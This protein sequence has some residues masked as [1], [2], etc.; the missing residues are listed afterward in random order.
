MSIFEIGLLPIGG[1]KEKETFKTLK[2]L[3][4]S[5]VRCVKKFK[6]SVEA[7]SELEFERGE[8]LLK[9]VDEL[10]SEADE[11]GFRFESELGDGA[12][13]PTFR[14]DLSRLA[15][16]I[17]D[18]ADLAEESIR[19]IHRRPKVFEKLAEAEEENEE[20]KI[21]RKGLVELAEIAVKSALVQD[22]AIDLLKKDMKEAAEKAEEIHRQERI[23]DEKEDELALK[24]YDFEELLDPI[25]VMQIRRLIDTFGAISNSA[26]ASGDILSAMI[27]AL[28][29]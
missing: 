20:I 14:G 23:S 12:F 7:Y 13:L 8:E 3:S 28:R 29:A 19:E 24:L 1:S 4:E 27:S 21:I 5:V 22:K 15:E 10:E 11:Y 18:T 17:D 16:S 6:E 9:E 26:E 2:G 25:S